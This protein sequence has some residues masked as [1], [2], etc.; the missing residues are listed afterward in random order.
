MRWATKSLSKREASSGRCD[1]ED[2]EWFRECHPPF[3]DWRSLVSHNKGFLI[4]GAQPD[5]N[6]LIR[7]GTCAINCSN[8]NEVYSFHTGGA[9]I[10]MADGSVRFVAKSIPIDQLVA[11]ASRNGQEVISFE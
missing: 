5:G 7:P 6:T 9:T 1:A 2:L 11:L 4:D 8:D 3:P 10:L